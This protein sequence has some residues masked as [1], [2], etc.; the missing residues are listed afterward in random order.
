MDSRADTC[1]LGK[2]FRH[3]GETGDVCNVR[4]FH[5]S[6][7]TLTDVPIVRGVTG[8]TDQT[9]GQSYLLYVNQGLWFGDKLDHSL[10]NP[11][12]IR[13]FGIPVSDD[14]YDNSRMSAKISRG[15]REER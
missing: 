15:A 12:Q 1:C 5:G 9:T 14:P 2:N 11:N 4:G 3:D 6:F 7:D 13:H 10:W 8:W